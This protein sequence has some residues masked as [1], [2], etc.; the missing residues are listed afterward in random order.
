MTAISLE[1]L[2]AELQDPSPLVLLDVRREQARAASG[3]EIPGTVWRNPALWLDWK[4]E[5]A[6]SPRVL[7]YCAHGHEISQGLTATLC[8]LGANASHVEGGF[9]AWQAAGRPVQPVPSPLA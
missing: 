1:D 4:D 2:V 8:A 9:S 5:F 3:L 6:Q 7:V